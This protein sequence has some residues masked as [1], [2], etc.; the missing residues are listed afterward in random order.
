MLRPILRHFEFEYPEG[1]QFWDKSGRVARDLVQ[2]IPGLRLRNQLIDQRDFFVP[3]STTELFYGVRLS[4]FRSLEE[5]ATEFRKRA[6]AFVEILAEE[7]EVENLVRFR[8]QAGLGWP[9][10]THDEAHTLAMKLLP[11][12]IGQNTKPGEFQ[13]AQLEVRKGSFVITTRY[14]IV[15]LSAP[16]GPVRLDESGSR[17]PH[18][19]VLVTWENF[20]TISVREFKLIAFFE[21]EEN[22]FAADLLKR[23]TAQADAKPG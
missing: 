9:C 8:F 23:I 20:A 17:V 14:T 10:Q 18:M 2:L 22:A 11:P 3:G 7:L 1:Y 16:P 6:S 12:E 21:E 15:D 13:G 5:D 19:A 4:S